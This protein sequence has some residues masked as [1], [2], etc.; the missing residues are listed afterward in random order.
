MSVRSLNG[1]SG[2][3]NIYVNTLSATSPLEIPSSTDTSST[4]SIKGLSG[5][6]SAGQVVKVNSGANGLEYGTESTSSN[7]VADGTDLRVLNQTAYNYVELKRTDDGDVGFK[8]N[9]SNYES[10]FYIDDANSDTIIETANSKL[11]LADTSISV[12]NANNRLIIGSSSTT[13]SIGNTTDIT[14]IFGVRTILNETEREIADYDITTTTLKI[15]NGTDTTEIYKPVMIGSSVNPLR[16]SFKDSDSNFQYDLKVSNLVANRDITLPL[17][18]GN[19]VFVFQDHTQ[20]LTNKTIT[21][22]F[23]GNLSGNATTATNL[24]SISSSDIVVK[25]GSQTLQDKLFLNCFYTNMKI[26][27]SSSD[28][29]YI[30]L[31]NELSADRNITLPLLTGNDEFTFNNHTQIL[32]NK[33]LTNPVITGTASDVNRFTIKDLDTSH[34][35]YFQVSNISGDRNIILPALAVNDTFCFEG[36]T[37]TLTNKTLTSPVINTSVSGSAILDEDDMSSNSNTKLATQQSI[38]AYVDN[39]TGLWEANT[40]GYNNIRPKALTTYNFINMER[41]DTADTGFMMRN[42]ASTGFIYVGGN[43]L[44]LEAPAGEIKLNGTDEAITNENDK[45]IIHYQSNTNQFGNET[46]NT[47]IYGLSIV[48]HNPLT[49]NNTI[50]ASKETQGCLS[51]LNGK[52]HNNTSGLPLRINLNTSGSSQVGWVQFT[53]HG[54]DVATY[55]TNASDKVGYIGSI[56]SDCKFGLYSGDTN[57]FISNPDHRNYVLLGRKNVYNVDFTPLSTLHICNDTNDLSAADASLT[58]ESLSSSYNAYITLRTNTGT[59]STSRNSYIESNSDGDLI[60]YGFGDI[61]FYVN[62]SNIVATFDINYDFKMLRDVDIY[63]VN[64]T[65]NTDSSKTAIGDLY[66]Q[67]VYA[68]DVYLEA[69]KYSDTIYVEG[70]PATGSSSG[71]FTKRF[72]IQ[73]RGLYLYQSPWGGSGSSS[74]GR[75]SWLITCGFQQFR[76]EFHLTSTD[77]TLVFM[78]SISGTGVYTIEYSFTGQHKSKSINDT[79]YNNIDNYIGLICYSTGEY[80]TYDFDTE[81]CNSDKDG[82][83]INDAMPIIDLTTTKKDK[84]VYG[85]ISNKENTDRTMNYGRFV[86]NLPSANDVNRVI[87]NSIGE[88]AIWI[89]NTNGNLEN[90]DYIQ[91]SNVA[92]YGEK[93]DDDLLHNYSVAKITC[94]CDFDINSIKYK[95][96]MVGDNIACFVGCI[97]FCG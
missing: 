43:K 69:L 30:L 70:S 40:T 83:T 8:L 75:A 96:K 23:T 3:N 87:I 42:S 62:N 19:D 88:G 32:T 11:K 72:E 91:S 95:S 28:H 80:A 68:E 4:I 76:L 53:S 27:D 36:H 29:N 73:N 90:G 10:K 35:Y 52:L 2:S 54:S 59:N 61:I 14:N 60:F 71:G 45:N 86:S 6:G 89:V 93:Q 64:S 13:I 46:E 97:Y 26:N 77:G 38:K 78:A 37:Q 12:N 48:I 9:N 85:V 57:F 81:T 63:G 25:T 92:G 47:K 49:I 15:G 39:A 55:A 84:R 34:T 58:I 7:W 66:A 51:L 56:S 44:I 22:T 20:T 21:G 74:V 41:S 17:L 1:L 50:S 94:D 16:M 33:T 18:T 67:D 79:I 31:V 24:A 5:F 65:T 82:I